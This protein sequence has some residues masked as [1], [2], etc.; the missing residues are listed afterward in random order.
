MLE[1]KW[2]DEQRDKV[3]CLRQQGRTLS[4]ISQLMGGMPESTVQQILK[5]AA[6][7]LRPGA[8]VSVHLANGEAIPHA[9]IIKQDATSL[10]LDVEGMG[11][12]IVFKSSVAKVVV[13]TLPI[14]TPVEFTE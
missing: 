9:R 4:Q 2:S 8:M 6:G 7:A 13:Q 3:L 14:T 11:E 10:T 12:V 5:K 1:R